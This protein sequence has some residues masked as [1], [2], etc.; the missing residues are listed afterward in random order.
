MQVSSTQ[1]RV[2]MYYRTGGQSVCTECVLQTCSW[3]SRSQNFTL[4]QTIHYTWSKQKHATRCHTLSAQFV[5][6][7]GLS[8]WQCSKVFTVQQDP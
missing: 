3:S 2:K 8:V 7:S 6:Y 4:L 1:T 5:L